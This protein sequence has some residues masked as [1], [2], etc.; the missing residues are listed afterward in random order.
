VVYRKV[1]KPEEPESLVKQASQTSSSSKGTPGNK[2]AK[3]GVNSQNRFGGMV[4]DD[5]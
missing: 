5:E 4:E 1:K 2:V 3:A